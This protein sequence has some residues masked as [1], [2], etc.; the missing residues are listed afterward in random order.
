MPGALAGVAL[1]VM[2]LNW[3]FFALR[4]A[5]LAA[6][7]F[8]V[9]ADDEPLSTGDYDGGTSACRGARCVSVLLLSG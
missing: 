4:Q 1:A 7:L 6:V 8:T 9:S 5:H 2:G 3:T